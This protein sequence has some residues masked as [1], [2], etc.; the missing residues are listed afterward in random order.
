MLFVQ[1]KRPTWNGKENRLIKLIAREARRII[2][3]LFITFYV[4][5]TAVSG[6][7]CGSNGG[8]VALCTA[9]WEENGGKSGSKILQVGFFSFLF[10]LGVHK[11]EVLSLCL[12]MQFKPMW[13]TE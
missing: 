6:W 12:L 8:A 5:A 3:T 9:T 2:A 11:V 1:R 4:A 7:L 13:L 10:L